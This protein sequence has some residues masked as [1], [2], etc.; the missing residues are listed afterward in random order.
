M[1]D[2][3]LSFGVFCTFS[4]YCVYRFFTTLYSDSISDFLSMSLGAARRG[5]RSPP[6]RSLL[7]PHTTSPGSPR[8]RLR[9][10]SRPERHRVRSAL[11]RSYALWILQ[12]AR[13]QRTSCGLCGD[14]ER[15]VCAVCAGG[16]VK[17]MKLSKHRR[18]RNRVASATHR[19]AIRMCV[20]TGLDRT[21]TANG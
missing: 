19:T 20:T 6:L 12:I 13:P 18:R 2:T 17:R 11:K 16:G 7:R 1:A 3:L 8:P 14:K 21:G 4:L 15:F 9:L 5:L 10:T